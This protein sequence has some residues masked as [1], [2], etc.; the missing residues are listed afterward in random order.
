MLESLESACEI[1]PNEVFGS[2]D[3]GIVSSVPDLEP[4]LQRRYQQIVAEHL[5][6]SSTVSAGLRAL[7]GAGLSFASTQAAWRFFSNPLVSLPALCSALIDCG[8]QLAASECEQYLLVVHDWS[9][10][11]YNSHSSK[12]DRIKIGSD[13]G[14]KLHAALLLS[15]G[16]GMPMSVVE[17][18]VWSAEG[19]YSTRSES[20]LDRNSTTYLDELS[21]T[22]ANLGSQDWPKPLVH[23]IDRGADSVAHYR[24][25]D[26]LKEKFVV[27]AKGFSHVIYEGRKMRLDEVAQELDYHSGQVVEVARGVQA[28]QLVAQ[29]EVIIERAAVKRVKVDGK[30]RRVEEAGKPIKMRLVVSKLL[31]PDDS[32]LEQWLLLTNVEE[33]A[34]AETIALWYY[35]RWAIESYFKL[36]KSGGHNLQEWQQESA[37]AIAKRILVVSMACCVVW[38]IMKM[39]GPGGEAIRELL[40]RLSG[41][42]VRR[43]RE[44]ASS[45][46]SGLWVLLAMIDAMEK[47]ELEELKQIAG[48]ILP[49]RTRRDTG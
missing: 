10:L 26:D 27:R 17:T 47:Y 18:N 49:N 44:T 38:Q 30:K 9:D 32:E 6:T 4:R 8:R 45:L 41:R 40:I 19:I 14:Y 34:S 33:T 39:K 7:P 13:L 37:A 31:L 23:I 12:S 36:M 29:A 15:D 35:F 24:L 25:W 42:Q 11:R 1:N 16:D 48:L 20:L 22:L 5:N 21:K 43:A 2:T 46:L 3:S 28:Q